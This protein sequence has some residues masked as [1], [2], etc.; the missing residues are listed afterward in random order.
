MSTNRHVPL[1]GVADATKRASAPACGEPF[2]IQNFRSRNKKA[3]GHGTP[4]QYAPVCTCPAA[5]VW[6]FSGSM[7]NGPFD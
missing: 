7:N 2:P 3:G 5:P 4:L 1:L 6:L